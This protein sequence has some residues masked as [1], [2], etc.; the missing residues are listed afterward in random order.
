MF[1]SII[2]DKYLGARYAMCDQLEILYAAQGGH[3]ELVDIIL[4]RCK[5]Y[6]E[7]RDISELSVH[8]FTGACAGQHLDLVNRM[9]KLCANVLGR[10]PYNA[11]PFKHA[12]ASES[13][14]A[15]H[16]LL[17]H[18]SEFLVRADK[19][20]MEEELCACSHCNTEKLAWIIGANMFPLS[21]ETWMR[22]LFL[23]YTNACTDAI[24]SLLAQGRAK[25]YEIGEAREFAHVLR[26]VHIPGPITCCFDLLC[27]YDPDIINLHVIREIFG[28]PLM[29]TPTAQYVLQCFARHWA[30]RICTESWGDIICAIKNDSASQYAAEVARNCGYLRE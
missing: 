21:R 10:H 24:R 16:Y 5:K 14:E 25:E 8:A 27:Q 4:S 11:M 15:V 30:S 29:N 18:H 20:L 3:D 26:R 28:L 12:L 13:N 22:Y 2:L 9:Y 17:A 1:G 6:N 7:K 19:Q 23:A